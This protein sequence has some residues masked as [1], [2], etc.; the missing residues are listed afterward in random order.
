MKKITLFL[1]ALAVCVTAFADEPITEQPA[2]VLKNYSREGKSVVYDYENGMY[3]AYQEGKVSIVFAED[4][5]T[6]YMKD[7][8]Y[9]M[10]YGTWVKG[11]INRDGT[12][13]KIPMG[14]VV[15]HSPYYDADV[16]LSWGSTS[17]GIINW[18]T[19]EVEVN[20]TPDETVSDAVFAIEGE[21]IR[22]LD[23]QGAEVLTADDL[24]E[25]AATG[26]SAIWADT[27]GWVQTIEWGTVLTEIPAAQPA[28]PANPEI[29]SW[30]DLGNESGYNRLEFKIDP[31]DVD[32]NPLDI[33]QGQ[34]TYS[35]FTDYDELFTF[36]SYNYG[37]DFNYQ[38]VTEVPY[39]QYSYN[40]SP[41][42]I[43]F[44]RTNA[45]GYDRF[46]EWRIGIQVYYTV[47]GVRNA[48]DIVYLEVFPEP[49]P[50]PDPTEQT[51]A[52]S[53]SADT[54]QG[55][56]A[57]FVT[58]TPSEESELFY[59]YSKDGG[60]WSEWLPYEDVIPFTEDGS[61]QVEAYAQAVNK[62]ESHHVSC[63]F[64]VTPRTGL[65]EL[66][67]DKA[68]AGVR[69][70]NVAGQEMAQPNGLTIVITTYSDGTTSAA[71]VMK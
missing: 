64:T 7:P 43:F 46:F 28:V 27:R 10:A 33:E 32:G 49:D 17:E 53:I 39:G 52:P 2:G 31:V 37:Y 12:L 36:D 65:D 29:V 23:S 5:E 56:H 22:L 42:S 20:Y 71:K 47:N 15:Y 57:Y 70:Y 40:F 13:I 67:G 61:Y 48:S 24:A 8:L 19:Y 1:A 16:I 26:L 44:Y 34:L 51:E 66:S 54:K 14:Q 21:T 9:A 63:S 62:T 4:G 69:Y 41:T 3:V 50:N 60:E 30:R 11:S 59:R 68:V 35:V 45:E 18:D 6:V 55:V 58:I 38:D 25:F